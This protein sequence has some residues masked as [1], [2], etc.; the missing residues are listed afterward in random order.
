M[1]RTCA[2][3]WPTCR[4]VP[5]RSQMRYS[6]HIQIHGE[7]KKIDHFRILLAQH[8]QRL[9]LH[10]KQTPQNKIITRCWS[11]NGQQRTNWSLIC[12]TVKRNIPLWHANYNLTFENVPIRTHKCTS[13]SLQADRQL[14]WCDRSPMLAVN[15]ESYSIF[16]FHSL[17]SLFILDKKD[18]WPF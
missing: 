4:H 10:A 14:L 9:A 5:T 7:G 1:K 11:Q 17:G 2:T 13:E 18:L 6:R 3:N 16:F 15:L 8:T 12:S